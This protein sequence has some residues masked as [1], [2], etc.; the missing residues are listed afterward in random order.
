MKKSGNIIFWIGIFL[1]VLTS[2][3]SRPLANLD[4]MWNFNVARCI[5]NGL[6]PYKDIS[7]VS[8]PLLGFITAIF[9]KIFGSEMFVTRILA[10][11]LAFGIL[12]LIYF[13]L[14]RVGI[15]KSVAGIVVLGIT[16][17]MSTYFCLDYNFFTV[18]LALF[19]ILLELKDKE[20]ST[21]KKKILIGIL[22]GLCVCTKQS[23]GI[24]ICFVI[25]INGL[26]FI[27]GKK[28]IK[29]ILK[30]IG[31][32]IIGIIIPIA[33]FIIYLLVNNAF[34]DFLDYCVYGISTFSNKIPYINLVNSE[35]IGF[36]IFSIIMPLAIIASVIANIVTKCLKKENSILYI[37]TIYSIPIFAVVF[38]ISD[39]IHFLIGIIP[40]IILIMYS[41]SLL[42]K[43]IEFLKA[44]CVSELLDIIYIV[45]IIACT[46]YIEIS[47]SDTLSNLSKYK[48]FNH[49]KNITVSE[50][51]NNN[52]DEVTTFINSSEKKVYILDS[53]AAAYMI[54]IDRYN[55]N[56]DMFLKGN[57]GSGGEA[58]QIENI[59]N[60]DALYLIMKDENARNWQ[61]PED[62]RAYIKENLKQVG[63]VGLY[64][65]YENNIEQ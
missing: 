57:L 3:L 54:P 44:N 51:L 31:F 45:S 6:V 22:G 19:I 27:K 59:K 9:L 7:M 65:I 58:A 47:Y 49:F 20:K 53:C 4:E 30:N 39:E 11:V 61:N 16:G 38:P 52:I 18:F 26:F 5:S 63:S 62:V 29:T 55:K 10:A 2:I 56:Y 23:I 41:S 37:L 43:K 46:L 64:D 34:N 35:K 21:I 13:I 8:T 15:K 24:L 40:T 50:S 14:K 32:R 17:V 48:K 28:D 25:V 42:I 33:I 36:K 12:M 60:E 1:I